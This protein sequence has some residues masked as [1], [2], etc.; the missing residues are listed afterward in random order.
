MAQGLHIHVVDFG[1][2]TRHLASLKESCL[3]LLKP[4]LRDGTITCGLAFIWPI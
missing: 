2:S 1:K 3:D 4:R